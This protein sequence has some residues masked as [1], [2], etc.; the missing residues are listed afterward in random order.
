VSRIKQ[1]VIGV[2]QSK[3]F[4]GIDPRATCPELGNLLLTFKA[5][6]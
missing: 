1:N 5:F 2:A 4:S 3:K 6:L